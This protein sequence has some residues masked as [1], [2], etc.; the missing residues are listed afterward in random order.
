MALDVSLSIHCPNTRAFANLLKSFIL[1]GLLTVVCAFGAFFVMHDFPDTAKF[2]TEDERAWAV[3]VGCLLQ[4]RSLLLFFQANNAMKKRLKY[5]G[6]LG[7]GRK[8]AEAS[9]FEWKYLRQALTDWQLY[10]SLFV[11]GLP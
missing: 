11:S 5:Q 1:E 9:H 4:G 2:L 10:L 6:S 7:S 8:I 3:Y